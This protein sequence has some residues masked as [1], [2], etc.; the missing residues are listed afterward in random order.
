MKYKSVGLTVLLAAFAGSALAQTPISG[1]SKCDKPG[2]SQ[3]IEVGDVA[4]HL[5]MIEKDTCSWSVPFEM[6]GLKSTTFTMAEAVDLT[7]AKTQDHGYVVIT[8][9]NGDQ[10]NV[11]FQG[12]SNLKNEGAFTGGGTWSFTRGTGKLK[13]L[14]GKGTY[15]ASLAP[16][17]AGGRI[18]MEGEYSLPE[19]SAATKKK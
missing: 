16:G 12:V 3:S 14:K 4:G 19:P 7:G 11:R 17:D 6:A 1:T 8:M 2:T 13:G 10:A 18:Q 9:E 15:Q 5:L